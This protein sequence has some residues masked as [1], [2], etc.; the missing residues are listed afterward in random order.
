M[1]ER[2]LREE[3]IRKEAIAEER[4]R[5]RLEDQI[6]AKVSSMLRAMPNF[7]RVEATKIAL[8]QIELE[9]KGAGTMQPLKNILDPRPDPPKIPMATIEKKKKTMT[10]EE[11]ERWIIYELGGKR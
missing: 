9:N 4:A 8:M 7:P 1:S 10:P 6:E 11:F 3:K 2:R 5:K